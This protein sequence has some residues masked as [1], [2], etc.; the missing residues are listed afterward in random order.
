[1]SKGKKVW[2]RW[3]NGQIQRVYIYKEFVINGETWYRATMN[4]KQ[5]V[6]K[7][8]EYGITWANTKGELELL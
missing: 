7:T 8:S 6:L 2:F 1:M 3:K 4:R 5:F